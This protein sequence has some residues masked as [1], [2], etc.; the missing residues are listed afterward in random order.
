MKKVAATH[1]C[2]RASS[3]LAAHLHLA[4]LTPLQLHLSYYIFVFPTIHS[5]YHSYDTLV[6]EQD[7][8]DMP[9]SFVFVCTSTSTL[10]QLR[11]LLCSI[12]TL[13]SRRYHGSIQALFRLSLSIYICIYI[14]FCLCPKKETSTTARCQHV[15]TRSNSSARKQT[16]N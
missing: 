13:L 15:T 16:R 3:S 5:C 7:S 1:G 10:L 8:R 14:H 2:H 11:L 12:K 9:Q 4:P 6:V